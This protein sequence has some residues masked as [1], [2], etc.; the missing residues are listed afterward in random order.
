MTTVDDLA[1]VMTEAPPPLAQQPHTQGPLRMTYEEYLNWSGEDTFAE[2][3]NEEVIIP[4]P[5]KVWHQQLVVF[6]DRV[7]GLFVSFFGL[8]QLLTAPV[9]V[10]LYPGGPSREPDLFFVSTTQLDRLHSG[11]CNG[12]PDLVIEI[13]SDDSVRR[14]RIEK[15][16]EYEQAGVREYWIIDNRPD[17]QRAWFYQ[18]GNFGVFERVLPDEHGVYRSQVLAGFWLRLDWLWQEAP[19]EL[20]AIAEV[21][22][23]EQVAEVLRSRLQA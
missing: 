3:V 23:P 16:D 1:P 6:L 18:L 12:A 19:D 17:Q 13:V 10:K 21:L 9:E 8:G 22:G 5:A 2:W 11:R 7:L 20:R 14:D 15:F 4:M